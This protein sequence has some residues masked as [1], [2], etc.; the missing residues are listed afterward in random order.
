MVLL[1][2]ST[3]AKEGDG[4]DEAS[5]DDDVGRGGEELITKKVQILLIHCVD[6]DPNHHE[7]E[8]RYLGVENT[9]KY[10]KKHI[11][12]RPKEY[13]IAKQVILRVMVLILSHNMYFS[14][15]LPL[16]SIIHLIYQ[17]MALTL[18]FM[19]KPQ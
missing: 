3:A 13:I 19:S 5:K 9:I 2:S 14:T 6:D 1:D 12:A 18:T 8:A 10:Q 17:L 11:L 4:K 7:H 15:A 16:L